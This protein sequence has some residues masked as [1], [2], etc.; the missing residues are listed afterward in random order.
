MKR[1]KDWVRKTKRCAAH[2]GKKHAHVKPI[3]V[4]DVSNVWCCFYCLPAMN[5]PHVLVY[6]C[7]NRAVSGVFGERN[8]RKAKKK[9]ATTKKTP[10]QI[11]VLP[12][13]RE[14]AKRRYCCP[15]HDK[16]AIRLIDF[17][18][19][20][21]QLLSSSSL[22]FFFFVWLARSSSTSYQYSETATKMR[23][24][25]AD[26]KH[27]RFICDCTLVR[28]QCAPIQSHCVSLGVWGDSMHIAFVNPICSLEFS[29]FVDSTAR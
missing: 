14:W 26:F 9:T 25:F 15:M 4:V 1:S 13:E 7:V 8:R 23:A 27:K 21:S 11:N 29:L 28:F 24:K 18:F 19:S 5:E 12:K 20:L 22:C 2:E 6:L 3:T 16:R 10:K 17:L